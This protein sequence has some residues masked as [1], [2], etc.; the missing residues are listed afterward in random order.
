MMENIDYKDCLL[1]SIYFNYNRI[2][3]EQQTDPLQVA[4]HLP[5]SDVLLP[6]QVV[7]ELLRLETVQT[8][9]VHLRLDL[10][11]LAPLLPADLL[12]LRQ[13][14]QLQGGVVD[15]DEDGDDDLQVLLCFL[16][17]VAVLSQETVKEMLEVPQVVVLDPLCEF[18]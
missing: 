11:Q 14:G 7:V 15:V 1:L 18:P 2:S 16:V 6:H 12:C 8:D 10:L 9:L 4:G 13:L 3:L 17:V 5:L